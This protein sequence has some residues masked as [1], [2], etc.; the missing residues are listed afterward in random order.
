M[1]VFVYCG[2]IDVDNAD[3]SRYV[4]WIILIIL[5]YLVATLENLGIYPIIRIIRGWAGAR[6]SVRGGW[7]HVEGR[8]ITGT[9]GWVDKS[10]KLDNRV[11]F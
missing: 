8:R 4:S 2:R 6:G 9:A 3:N 10:D 7:G 11:C 1:G 5:A